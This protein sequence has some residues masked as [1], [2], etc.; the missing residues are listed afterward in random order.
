MSVLNMSESRPRMPQA[1]VYY[2]DETSEICN[3]ININSNSRQ[4]KD[5]DYGLF[6]LYSLNIC[7]FD[8]T[9]YPNVVR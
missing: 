2:N 3:V 6:S 7:K 1:L 4:T 8:F 9:K 5:N